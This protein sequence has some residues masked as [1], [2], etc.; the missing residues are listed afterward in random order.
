MSERSCPFNKGGAAFDQDEALS[1]GLP[2]KKLDAVWEKV[3]E[4][5]VLSSG[6]D[7]PSMSSWMSEDYS[8]V[9]ENKLDEQEAKTKVLCSRGVIAKVR[10]EWF[11]HRKYT[12]LFKKADHGLI[13]LSSAFLGDSLPSWLGSVSSSKIFPCCALKFFRGNCEENDTSHTGNFL[14]G[15][16]KTGQAVSA[17]SICP[18]SFV[19]LLLCHLIV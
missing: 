16:K 12:G 5:R 2:A 3:I 18:L 15:G 6:S 17:C 19:C 11:D 4:N 7:W 13:R 8:N 1:T 9:Y 14:F 10:I